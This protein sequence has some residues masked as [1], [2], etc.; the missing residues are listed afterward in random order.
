MA[1]PSSSARRIQS[2]TEFAKL[3]NVEWLRPF[4]MQDFSGSKMEPFRPFCL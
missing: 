1:Y 2:R 3:G 4:I